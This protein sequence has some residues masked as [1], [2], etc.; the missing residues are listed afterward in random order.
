MPQI[1]HRHHP[2]AHLLQLKHLRNMK[3]IDHFLMKNKNLNQM[4]LR[5]N[6]MFSLNLSFFEISCF[7]FFQLFSIGEENAQFIFLI[8]LRKDLKET[9][10]DLIYSGLHIQLSLREFVHSNH[11]SNRSG[12][13]CTSSNEDIIFFQFS[14]LC[15]DQGLLPCNSISKGIH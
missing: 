12:K 5:R 15:K 11:K 9:S 3:K 7:D 10:Y 14:L 13:I 8:L 6:L 2:C 4:I 1:L